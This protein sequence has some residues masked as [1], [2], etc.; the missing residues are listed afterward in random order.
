MLRLESRT[1]KAQ[2]DG[3]PKAIDTGQKSF[4]QAVNYLSRAEGWESRKLRDGWRNYCPQCSEEA[5]PDL[6]IAGIGFIKEVSD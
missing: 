3:C 1:W 2:C 4:Q 6:E 5:D